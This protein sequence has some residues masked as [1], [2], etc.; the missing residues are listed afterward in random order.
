MLSCSRNAL[1]SFFSSQ[2]GLHLGTDADVQ[3]GLVGGPRRSQLPL[4]VLW[5]LGMVVQVPGWAGFP[6][7]GLAECAFS[8]ILWGMVLPRRSSAQSSSFVPDSAGK[9]GQGSFLWSLMALPSPD[10]VIS[11]LEN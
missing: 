8:L 11:G 7:L 10:E 9:S 5:C 3:E 2:Q 6:V 1:S 4:Q